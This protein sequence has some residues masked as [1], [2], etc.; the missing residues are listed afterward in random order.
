[1]AW[2]IR[3]NGSRY[4]YWSQRQ[5]DG[6]VRRRYLG[7][8]IRAEVES[9]RI[10]RK[11]V[12]REML[13]RERRQT[14]ELERTTRE[15]ASSIRVLLEAHYFAAGFHN[16]GSRGWRRRRKMIK[17]TEEC[18]EDSQSDRVLKID[19]E[20]E[21]MTMGELVSRCRKGDREAAKTLR[22]V[23]NEYPDLY[24]GLGQ[25]SVKVQTK[26]IQ[27][28]AGQ[29]LFEREMILR[30][31]MELRK[32]LSEEGDGT[33][34]ERLAIEQVISSYLQLSYHEHREAECPASDLRIAEHRAN[35][36]ERASRRHMKALGALTTLRLLAPKMMPQQRHTALPNGHQDPQ[37][38][39][40]LTQVNGNR[41]A[42]A[43]DHSL[44]PVPMN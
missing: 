37:L 33:E 12:R 21:R 11:Q 3:E 36:I 2:E 44:H 30:A 39:L 22:H 1:M 31:T 13:A 25:A 14:T 9:I 17:P 19:A 4:F 16:P 27:A 20:T 23:L 35:Q 40:E 34:L 18:S 43:F 8:G 6:S 29:D 26:W 32:S 10:E 28:I 15:S 5:S 24:Q 41:L 42:S 7:N 38:L